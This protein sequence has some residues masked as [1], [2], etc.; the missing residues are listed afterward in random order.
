MQIVL[1]LSVSHLKFI[2]NRPVLEK[3]VVCDIQKKLH[4]IKKVITHIDR[5]VL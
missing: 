4:V 5:R 1:E 2:I 3:M